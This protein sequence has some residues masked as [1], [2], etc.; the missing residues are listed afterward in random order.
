MPF[1][2]AVRQGAIGVLIAPREGLCIS[3]T[4]GGLLPF[5]LC[6]Q[7]LPRPL[8][9]VRRTVPIDAYHRIV[10]LQWVVVVGIAVVGAE[11][12]WRIASSRSHTFRILRVCDLVFVNQVSV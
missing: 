12:G 2:H 7:P 3:R 4:T 1:V 5:G 9:V 10:G 11:M 6:R 8:A